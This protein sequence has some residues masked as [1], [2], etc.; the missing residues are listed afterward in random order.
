MVISKSWMHNLMDEEAVEEPNLVPGMARKVQTSVPF[1]GRTG[2][3]LWGRGRGCVSCAA[4]WV[5][6]L[7]KAR[8]NQNALSPCQ[9]FWLFAS[10][11]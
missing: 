11:G 7:F 6:S 10:I 4:G 9:T 8:C 3:G 5:G 1:Y 2:V